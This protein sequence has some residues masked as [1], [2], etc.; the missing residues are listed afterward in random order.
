MERGYLTFTLLSNDG[1]SKI[2]HASRVDLTVE[3]AQEKL[4]T[5]NQVFENIIRN[6]GSLPL[7]TDVRRG[8]VKRD[9]SLNAIARDE[10]F[11][12][13]LGFGGS[14]NPSAPYRSYL[15]ISQKFPM[16]KDRPPI[17]RKIVSPPE[18]Y[19]S[20]DMSPLIVKPKPSFSSHFWKRVESYRDTAKDDR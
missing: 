1:I 15:L 16:N 7:I 3:Q 13:N 10:K 14:G 8:A 20:V 5:F 18:G 4:N 19:E 12:F 9:T 2:S 17:R 6:K 11:A